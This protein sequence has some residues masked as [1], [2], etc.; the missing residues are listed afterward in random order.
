[1]RCTEPSPGRTIG[2]HPQQDEQ[3]SWI[4]Q[5]SHELRTPLTP[6]KGY[7]L[8][9]QRQD[10]ALTPSERQR[11]YEVLL[12]EEQRLEDLV[13]HL[14][15]ATTLDEGA[16]V[17]VP[18]VLDWSAVVADQVDLYRRSDP[19]RTITVVD[20]GQPRVSQVVADA[21]L[22]AGVLANLLSNAIK[23]SPEGSPIEVTTAVDGDCVVTSVSDAGYGVP[24]RD[25][26]RVFDRYTR[27]VDR[28]RARPGVGLGLH[29]ARRSVEEM[30]GQ[31]H[32]GEARGGGAR[33]TFSLPRHL[34]VAPRPSATQV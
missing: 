30:G 33:F 27:L 18:E 13:S 11:I 26:E 19:T 25:R 28:V 31:I 32:C 21:T 3:D 20:T 5:V 7:L 15:L 6:I 1:M 17:V 4:A 16:A 23:Y 9:L 2:V 24:A 10:E 34:L 8:T 12:R 22:S 29:I 14:L